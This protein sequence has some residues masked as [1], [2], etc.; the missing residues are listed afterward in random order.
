MLAGLASCGGFSV[1]GPQ[2]PESRGAGDGLR[3]APAGL[4]KLFDSNALRI[5]YFRFDEE[6]RGT[7]T[8][9]A[10]ASAWIVYSKSWAHRFGENVSE[11]YIK[12]F[13]KARV[14]AGDQNQ[15]VV[16]AKGTYPDEEVR[17]HVDAF[18]ARDLLS[19]P[20]VRMDEIT[21]EY[22]LKMFEDPERWRYFRAISIASD[23]GSHTVLLLSLVGDPPADPPPRAALHF[24]HLEAFVA[25]VVSR[26][27]IVT[28]T[29]LPQ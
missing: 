9:R 10:G 27:A 4:R 20:P 11:P 14:G 17:K 25:G 29:R 16:L 1:G 8:K 13:P 22:T 28:Q 26:L 5:S 24:G 21:R 7:G 15:G 23:Q 12:A 19:L 18:L 2:T 6:D 3:P